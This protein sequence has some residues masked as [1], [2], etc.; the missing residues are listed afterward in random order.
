MGSELYK[1]LYVLV[2]LRVTQNL[3]SKCQPTLQ[4]AIVEANDSELEK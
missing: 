4:L 2:D 3:G 1:L